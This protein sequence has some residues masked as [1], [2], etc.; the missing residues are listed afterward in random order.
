MS[1][2]AQP[3]W[4]QDPTGRYLRRYWD[5]NNWTDHV[6]QADGST[7]NESA[8]P[9]VAPTPAPEFPPAFASESA[10]VTN[11]T[12]N[13]IA[14]IIGVVSAAAALIGATG[15]SWVSVTSSDLDSGNVKFTRS[16]LSTLLSL[17]GRDGIK[18][19]T[20][21]FIDFGWLVLI[22][23]ACWA[24][25]VGFGKLSASRTAVR[26]ASLLLLAWTIAALQDIAGSGDANN[27]VSMA[28]GGYVV[29]AAAVGALVAA[30]VPPSASARTR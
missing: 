25:M 22:A 24:A 2:Q 7:I 4:H 10:S 17:V 19:F 11:P 20:T 16:D 29:I 5:G 13:P 21:S 12:A 26:V 15:L 18:W 28:V 14:G 6:Q 3:G 27:S 8:V 1:N 30:I 23:V 9:A